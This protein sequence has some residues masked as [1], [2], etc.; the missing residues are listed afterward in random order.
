MGLKSQIKPRYAE[1]SYPCSVNE[2]KVDEYQL[3]MVSYTI[4][5]AM[6]TTSVN[7]HSKFGWPRSMSMPRHLLAS[8]KK[9]L[10]RRE[11]LIQE[12]GL[13]GRYVM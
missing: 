8:W 10:S 6:T 4:N 5:W 12:I 1:K 2:L 7:S 3:G 9:R 13:G 11:A